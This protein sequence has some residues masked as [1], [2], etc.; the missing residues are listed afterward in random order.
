[1]RV[2][3]RRLRELVPLMGWDQHTT[4]K[5][6]RRLRK[7]T[8]RLGTVREL[9][10]LTLFIE[11]LR[12]SD[13][14]PSATLERVEAAV[15]HSRKA[16]RKR[17]TAKLPTGKLQRIADKLERA[18]KPA[19]RGEGTERRRAGRQAGNWFWPLEA[20]LARRARLVR[21]A[22]ETAGALYGVEHVH[23]VRT[24]LKKLRY[25]AE[26]CEEAGRP[27]LLADISALKSAQD[28]LG[29]L[30]DMEV[31]VAWTRQVQASLEPPNFTAWRQL[32]SLE[33]G[34]EDEC[35]QLHARYVSQRD[36]I[37]SIADRLGAE[38]SHAKI[39][40]AEPAASG[41]LPAKPSQSGHEQQINQARP[42][43]HAS[44]AAEA[45]RFR[46]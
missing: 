29:R 27:H 5:L 9:D 36:S 14:Y 43:N 26:L 15:A 20:R 30:H 46:A 7:V 31:F 21:S 13:K 25:A 35:R 1:M 11:E 3:S 34:I 22:I 44:P 18:L 4:R 12:A 16:A 6:G 45:R 23:D 41:P 37:A 42:S 39:D 24:A 28:L 19:D 2:A 8:R 40:G 33:R 10:V 38:A 32:E 17:L